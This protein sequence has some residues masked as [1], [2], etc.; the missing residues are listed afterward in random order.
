[1]TAGLDLSGADLVVRS[2]DDISLATVR[3]LVS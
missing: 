2:L 3:G 1:M